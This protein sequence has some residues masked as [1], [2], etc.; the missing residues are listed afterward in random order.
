MYMFV[1]TYMYVYSICTCAICVFHYVSCIYGCSIYVYVYMHIDVTR[2][3]ER[4]P[5][6]VEVK[7][8]LDGLAGKVEDLQD[9]LT[10]AII[11]L[12]PYDVRRAQEVWIHARVYAWMD[13]CIRWMDGWLVGCV[14]VRS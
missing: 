2:R 5:S 7:V 8:W 12:P 13:S 14:C 11:F 4:V 1:D 9:K 3:L 6:E 10:A